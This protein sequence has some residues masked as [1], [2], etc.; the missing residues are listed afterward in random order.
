MIVGALDIGS[1]KVCCVIARIT[2]DKKDAPVVEVLGAS[3]Q[4]SAGVENGRI[5]DLQPLVKVLRETVLEA[6][7]MA[8]V[9]LNEVYINVN[10]EFVTCFNVKGIIT[11]TPTGQA[12]PIRRP[13][14]ERV[15]ES[16]LHSLSL[17]SGQVILHMLAQQFI[18]DSMPGVRNPVD[19]EGTKLEADFHV[20]TVPQTVLNNVNRCVEMAGL[21]ALRYFLTPLASAY[22]VTNDFEREQGVLVVDIGAGTTGFVVIKNES[23]YH[24]YILPLGGHQFTLDV[25]SVLDTPPHEAE[26]LKRLVG[27]VYEAPSPPGEPTGEDKPDTEMVAVPSLQPRSSPQLV[28]RRRIAEILEARAE[29]LLYLIRQHLEH[30]RMI[31]LVQRVVL[32]GGGALLGGLDR[33]ARAVFEMPVRVGYPIN[34]EGLRDV[35]NSP[36]YAVACGIVHLVAQDDEW[37]SR[38]QRR[39]GILK[40]LWQWVRNMV[41]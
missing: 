15:R 21:R 12:Q 37:R 32:T 31:D 10:G 14:V 13:D 20:V 34:I 27:A 18:V 3:K 40:R 8:G 26:R 36:V 38:L 5:V 2:W 7:K 33:V 11:L 29:E 9:R 16:A 39:V 30:V 1:H 22:S 19:M 17:P 35:V 23:L 6:S 41:P 28:P 25:A 24:S 4:T